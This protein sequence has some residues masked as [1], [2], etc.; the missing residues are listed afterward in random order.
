MPHKASRAPGV[1]TQWRIGVFLRNIK[2]VPA[3]GN[4]A[5][6]FVDIQGVLI[7]RDGCYH[8]KPVQLGI[9]KAMLAKRQGPTYSSP[10]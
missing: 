8:V 1:S 5:L 9:V 6:K 10:I 4:P 3:L 7:M 2:V